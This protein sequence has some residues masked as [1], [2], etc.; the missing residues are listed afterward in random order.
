M[1]DDLNLSFESISRVRAALRRFIVARSSDGKP[2]VVS[3]ARLL[4]DGVEVF[5]SGPQ[6]AGVSTDSSELPVGGTLQLGPALTPGS[7]LLELSVT[8]WGVKTP[9]RATRTVDFEIIE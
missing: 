8:D 6:P 2:Q 4:R 9:R 3:E 1:V 7:Y 5:R